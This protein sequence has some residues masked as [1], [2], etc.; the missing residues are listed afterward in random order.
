MQMEFLSHVRWRT[1]TTGYYF[2]IN[3]FI[4]LGG[5]RPIP[6]PYPSQHCYKCI[7]RGVASR[8]LSRSFFAMSQRAT[9]FPIPVLPSAYSPST[10]LSCKPMRTFTQSS[11]VCRPFFFSHQKKDGKDENDKKSDKKASQKMKERDSVENKDDGLSKF[12][13]K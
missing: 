11:R 9:L 4:I 8:Y 2:V 1:S 5:I 10:I 6:S 12:L 3:L 13:C 7:L